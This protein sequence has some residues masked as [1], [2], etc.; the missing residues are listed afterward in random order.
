MT[1]YLSP[2]GDLELEIA[3]LRQEVDLE[4]ERRVMAAL[5]GSRDEDCPRPFSL[6]RHESD[7]KNLQAHGI[8]AYGVVWGEDLSVTVR[9][10]RFTPRRSTVDVSER[11]FASLPDLRSRLDE[12]VKLVWLSEDIDDLASAIR[13]DIED[14]FR[15]RANDGGVRHAVASVIRKHDIDGHFTWSQTARIADDVL[16]ALFA[17]EGKP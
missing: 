5:W 14:G 2:S 13:E 7:A 10:Q 3:R 9:W 8:L 15:L 16:T 17:E 11:N 4:R 1:A 12:G 6:Y